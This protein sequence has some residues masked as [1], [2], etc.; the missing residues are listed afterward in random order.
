MPGHKPRYKWHSVS[1]SQQAQN[2]PA[3]GRFFAV[4]IAGIDPEKLFDENA[5]RFLSEM[6]IWR[7]VQPAYEEARREYPDLRL[8][9]ALD[10]GL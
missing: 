8:A 7:Y 5:Q 2:W 4:M 6:G 10:N 3:D 1:A 9:V